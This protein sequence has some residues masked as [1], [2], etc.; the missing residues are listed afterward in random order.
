MLESFFKLIVD[1]V[2][3]N[4]KRRQEKAEKARAGERSLREE[5]EAA[6]KRK[7]EAS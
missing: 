6:E 7:R 4:A 3:W 5:L 2:L 1:A